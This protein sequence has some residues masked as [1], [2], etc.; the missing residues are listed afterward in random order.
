MGDIAANAVLA[1]LSFLPSRRGE[2]APK[3]T[4][5]VFVGQPT[6][7]AGKIERLYVAEKMVDLARRHPDTQF[8]IKPRHRPGEKTLHRMRYHYKTLMDEAGIVAPSTSFVDCTT[9]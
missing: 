5:V 4:D 6:V 9:R 3:G 2:E 8:V 7:P 1:G